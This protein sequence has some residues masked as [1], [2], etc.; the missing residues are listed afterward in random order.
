MKFLILILLI[1]PLYSQDSLFWFDMRQVRDPIPSTPKV[2]DAIYGTSQLK[3]LDSLKN[4]NKTT[5]TGYRVQVYETSSVEMANKILKKFKSVL[6]DSLYVIFE[7][8]LY[9]VHYGNY[10]DKNDAEKSKTKLVNKGYKNIWVV[11]SRIDQNYL[12]RKD[13]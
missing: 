5:R 10:I 8:P 13:S 6:D 12:L 11:K 3:I 1:F 7:A 2:L 9:K 4:I